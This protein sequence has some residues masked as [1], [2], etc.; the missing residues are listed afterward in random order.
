MWA[1]EWKE[2]VDFQFHS[3]YNLFKT[4]NVICYQRL[5]ILLFLVLLQR[6]SNY[7]C[8]WTYLYC[9]YTGLSSL[10]SPLLKWE[11]PGESS[12]SEAVSVSGEIA[13]GAA[14][15]PHRYP[16]SNAIPSILA[17]M[18][19]WPKAMMS[20]VCCQTCLGLFWPT[21]YFPIL[22]HLSYGLNLVNKKWRGKRHSRKGGE[23]TGL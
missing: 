20:L 3:T 23:R 11:K 12:S 17:G 4:K 22:I 10:S 1:S 16:A 15:A 14:C 7:V 18:C 19:D 5:V 13:H 9:L 21:K 8:I 6:Q 2:N